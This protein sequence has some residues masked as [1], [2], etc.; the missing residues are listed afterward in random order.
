VKSLA[1]A[2]GGA[3]ALESDGQ[4]AGS[5][6]S[7]TIPLALG[8]VASPIVEPVEPP[9]PKRRVLVVDDQHDVADVLALLLGTLGQ[10]VAV[11][12]DA[13]SAV[14]LARQ[15]RPDVAFLDVSMPGV[16]GSEL[17]NQL[18]AEFAPGELRLV[19]VTGHDK[20]D[21][22]VAE[23]QFDQHLLKPVTV[24]GVVAVLKAASAGTDTPSKS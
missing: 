5:T 13:Q 24:A 2:H 15:R 21:A 17:A 9:P 3:V 4:G 19:A 22:R 14:A 1:E 23:G 20:H 18:R 8:A 10:D 11:A 12:Y 16:T 6:F 7:V